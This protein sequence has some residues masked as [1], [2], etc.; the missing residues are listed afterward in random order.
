M[1]EKG[2]KFDFQPSKGSEDKIENQVN[3]I[4]ENQPL[5]VVSLVSSR[6]SLTTSNVAC[7]SMGSPKYL[8]EG[9]II[10]CM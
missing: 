4:P 6:S 7:T 8:A 3:K 10:R 5:S 1:V 2:G 9:R